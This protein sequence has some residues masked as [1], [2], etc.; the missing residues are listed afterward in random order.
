M[1]NYKSGLNSERKEQ[2]DIFPDDKWRDTRWGVRTI[3]EV[4]LNRVIYIR[5]RGGCE[6]SC[7]CSLNEFQLEFS[8]LS[9]GIHVA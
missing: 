1:K 8:F 3:S 4:A 6:T 7:I 5:I 2:P 9:S